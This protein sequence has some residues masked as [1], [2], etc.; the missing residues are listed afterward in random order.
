MNTGYLILY[1]KSSIIESYILNFLM[2]KYISLNNA[3]GS[4][5]LISKI[6]YYHRNYFCFINKEKDSVRCIIKFNT[7]NNYQINIKIKSQQEI[8]LTDLKKSE[9]FKSE[10]AMLE[11]FFNLEKNSDLNYLN[12]KFNLIIKESNNI[13]EFNCILLV[14]YL[15]IGIFEKIKKN[16]K[17]KE[18]VHN[19]EVQHNLRTN[20][21]LSNILSYRFAFRKKNSDNNGIEGGSTMQDNRNRDLNK[22][23]KNNEIIYYDM[24]YNKY[25]LYNELLTD[26]N[27]NQG[28]NLFNKDKI[29]DYIDLD[30]KFKSIFK[31]SSDIFTKPFSELS[32]IKF[33]KIEIPD[34]KKD[35]NKIKN[36]N[37]NDQMNP[38]PVNDQFRKEEN[39]G[40]TGYINYQNNN[41]INRTF[42]N[43]NNSVHNISVVKDENLVNDR[44]K[45]NNSY[46][47]YNNNLYFK[48]EFS[49]N[50]FYSYNREN[51]NN[52][53]YPDN[54]G[55]YKYYNR[56]DSN[57]INIPG[58]N[59]YEKYESR[60]NFRESNQ[61]RSSY[62]NIRRSDSYGN[63][64]Y[65]NMRNNSNNNYS[66]H[67]SNSS[68]RSEKGR[69]YERSRSVSRNETPGQSPNRNDRY[70]NLDSPRQKPY[71]KYNDRNNLNKNNN[72][73][74]DNNNI[75]YYYNINNYYRPGNM[76]RWNE[77][78]YYQKGGNFQRNKPDYYNNNSY[79][80]N[81]ESNYIRQRRRNSNG[82]Y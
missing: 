72:Y 28:Q 62:N 52:N 78:N 17:D 76:N 22:K 79:Y 51:N 18:N 68:F 75:N 74:G 67:S 60:N 53:Y 61:I 24:K 44:F 8:A 66:Y 35:E 12:N 70:Y 59:R 73:Y 42:N 6:G 29:N 19:N 23:E 31:I 47:S 30:N 2:A 34:D 81:R 49:N 27:E 20:P 1:Y 71:D 46:S 5:E 11:H 25:F 48:K 39:K 63:R 65:E 41:N 33:D 36:V 80:S 64:N 7:I 15:D 69:N 45:R 32:D 9:S 26:K 55:G 37:Y 58:D 10:D 56:S 21:F 3:I 13:Y 82:G 4:N 38:V 57:N 14:D 43:Y 54:N 50:S 40:N 16:M 77:G